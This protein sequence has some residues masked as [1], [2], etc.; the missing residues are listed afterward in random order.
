MSKDNISNILHSKGYKYLAHITSFKNYNNLIKN[1][2]IIHNIY[3]R[4]KNKINS[5][6][7]FSYCDLDFDKPFTLNP[8]DFPGVYMSLVYDLDIYKEKIK[9]FDDLK[10]NVILIFPLELLEQQNWH[11]NINDRCGA[12][13]YDTY[14]PEN[15]SSSPH[16]D[17][18]ISYY[19]KEKYIDNEVIFHHSVHL[20]N[21]SHLIISDND[22]ISNPVYNLQINMNLRRNCI[23]Y[24]DMYYS[25]ADICYYKQPDVYT[26]SDEFYIDLMRRE[27]PIE[28]KYLCTNVN[29]KNKDTMEN[30]IMN[31]KVNGVD[32]F[33][34]LYIQ[35][36]NI[37]N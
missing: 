14:F 35:N 37:L 6:G 36:Q 12:I 16:I 25:G 23:F 33:T 9:K 2:N 31:F 20:C 30:A 3:D 5:R 29:I 15:I 32:L 1:T 19:T 7:I 4:Y 10:S 21:A 22:I 28:Y 18:I 17:D 26:T 34:Y 8:G 24:S 13:G 27:L 11:F